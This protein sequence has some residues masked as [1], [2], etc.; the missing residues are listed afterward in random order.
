MTLEESGASF[1]FLSLCVSLSCLL[2]A[3]AF[4]DHMPW[5]VLCQYF[6]KISKPHSVQVV[7]GDDDLMMLVLS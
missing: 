7:E 6:G 2:R 1:M 3:H 4:V 5:G